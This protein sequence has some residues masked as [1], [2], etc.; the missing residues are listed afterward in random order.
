MALLY[1]KIPCVIVDTGGNY[2][3]AWENIRRLRVKG[4]RIIVLAS[5]NKR[6]PYYYDYIKDEE[7]KPFYKSCSDKAKQ[8]HLDYFYKTIGPAIVNI[9]LTADE[10][11]R[12][13][14][15]QN[16]NWIKY[17]FPLIEHGYTREMC[18][19]LL[20]HHNLLI[21]KTGC[22]FCAKQ[23]RKSWIWLKENHP[24]K[25]QECKEMGWLTKLPH[26]SHNM[27]KPETEGGA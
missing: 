12:R 26:I 14:E 24:D 27:T 7:L 4:H 23:P 13:D 1:P 5:L 16:N 17:N 15:F 9:G 21:I 18:E 20:R 2:D 3:E 11:D 8:N 6:Y 19:K 22:W 10:P 25:Y